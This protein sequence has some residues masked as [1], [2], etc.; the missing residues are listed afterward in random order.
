MIVTAMDVARAMALRSED[1]YCQVGAVALTKDN[2]IIATAYSGLL[3]GVG[4]DMLQMHLRQNSGK[5]SI[6]TKDSDLRNARLPFMVH[7]EQ[8]LCSLIRRNEATLTVVTV[9]PCASCTLLLAVHGIRRIVFLQEY[10]RDQAAF[11]LAKFYGMSISK[12]EDA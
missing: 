12:F 1:P 6:F 11:D 8:N 7:A 4:W 2:R 3:P 5:S 9:M 10:A